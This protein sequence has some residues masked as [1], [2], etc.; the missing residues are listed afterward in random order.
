[1]KLIRTIVILIFL[2]AT[3]NV[4][5]GQSRVQPK[6]IKIKENY[7]HPPTHF[8]FPKS[9]FDDYQLESVYSFDKKNNNIGVT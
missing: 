1:M 4:A 2:F 8:N 5:N 7:T 6:K 9:L 3:F